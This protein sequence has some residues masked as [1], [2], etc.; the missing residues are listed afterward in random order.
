[1][2]E[3]PP[4]NAVGNPNGG[5]GEDQRAP[6]E[7]PEQFP[8]RGY[9]S[10]LGSGAGAAVA[11]W[12]VGSEQLFKV[13]GAP[14][15]SFQASHGGGSCQVSFSTDGGKTFRVVKSFIGDCPSLNDQ[16]NVNPEDNAAHGTPVSNGFP[17]TV[18][19]DLPTGP[20]L[21]AWT[22]YVFSHKTITS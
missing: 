3:P 19:K 11:Q 20:A 13:F 1:M 15:P 14:P 9:Q 17:F 8:C 16:A 10:L 21:F 7:G 4:I 6:L 2:S 18:P 5:K 22:W 12:D